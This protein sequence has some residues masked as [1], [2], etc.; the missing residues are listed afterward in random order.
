MVISFVVV[1]VVFLFVKVIFVIS[2]VHVLILEVSITIHILILGVYVYIDSLRLHWVVHL[3][4]LVD[5][6]VHL[7]GG[8]LHHLWISG[9]GLLGV[10]HVDIVAYGMGLLVEGN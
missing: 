7:R 9:I 2:I 6:I 4:R 1:S 10:G 5:L 3:V 8:S